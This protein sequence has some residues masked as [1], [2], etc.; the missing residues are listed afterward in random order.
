M[1]QALQEL[2]STGLLEGPERL[3]QLA[4]LERH[5]TNEAAAYSLAALLVLGGGALERGGYRRLSDH[6]ARVGHSL[7]KT[8][9]TSVARAL[10][11][12]D[13]GLGGRALDVPMVASKLSVGPYKRLAGDQ[14][15][16]KALRYVLA[17]PSHALAFQQDGRFGWDNGPHRAALGL[18]Y[19]W[20]PTVTHKPWPAESV[21]KIVP[22]GRE[23]IATAR[24]D[25]PDDPVLELSS[26]WTHVAW[27]RPVV[28]EPN[29]ALD[30]LER[31]AQPATG[32]RPDEGLRLACAILRVQVGLQ[33]GDRAGVERGVGET[34]RL[35]RRPSTEVPRL[36]IA[37]AWGAAFERDLP[38][39]ERLVAPVLDGP[40]EDL[41]VRGAQ[42][43]WSSGVRGRA[44]GV[45]REVSPDF[46]PRSSRLS[47]PLIRNP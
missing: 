46:R 33:L 2:L 13:P 4:R 32:R 42:V 5:T 15:A 22:A 9:R 41:R 23:L 1:S 30:S 21:Q 45:F 8:V 44:E 18:S 17:D 37:L 43:L 26:L 38:A 16:L 12:T 36:A 28:F 14:R 40:D 3:R 25:H 7:F 35:L 39:V 10:L 34:E 47:S 6:D 31:M 27:D 24:R 11:A 20:Q 29:R 19:V